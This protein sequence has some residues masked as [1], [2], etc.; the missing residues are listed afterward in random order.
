MKYKLRNRQKPAY[1]RFRFIKRTQRR[2]F[3]EGLWSQQH[4][5]LYHISYKRTGCSINHVYWESTSQLLG[6][7]ITLFIGPKIG[8]TNPSNLN[9]CDLWNTLY[10]LELSLNANQFMDKYLRRPDEVVPKNSWWI[11]WW[12]ILWYVEKNIGLLLGWFCTSSDLNFP[13]EF[14]R[15]K[16]CFS[17]E[18][19]FM[20]SKNQWM[21]L[22]GCKS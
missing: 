12:W 19:T 14:N 8:T 6:H 7:R 16:S 17:K 1:T 18:L 5:F 20:D 10:F 21:A 13:R 9:R 4:L 15:I 22:I 2:T 11:L 3:L